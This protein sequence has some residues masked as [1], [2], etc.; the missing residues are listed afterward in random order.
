[1][2]IY[3]VASVEDLKTEYFE[4]NDQQVCSTVLSK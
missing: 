4:E 3:F 2:T 1:M